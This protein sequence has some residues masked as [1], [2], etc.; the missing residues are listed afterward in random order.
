MARC[1]SSEE[2]QIRIARSVTLVNG[3]FEIGSPKNGKGRTVSLPAFVADLLGERGDL[4]ALVF[5]DSEGGHMRGTQRAA[6]VVVAGRRGR[7]ALPPHGRRG[8]RSCYDFKLHELR[9]TAA[10]LAIQAGRE[11]QGVAEHARP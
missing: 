6:A 10:S 4:D 8:S 5:P 2:L 1:R 9:H 11:H 7:P 3:V